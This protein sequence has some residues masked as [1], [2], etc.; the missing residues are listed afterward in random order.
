MRA[1]VVAS[2]LFLLF[3]LGRAGG[4]VP[5]SDPTKE[6]D[7]RRLIEL[8]GSAQLTQAMMNQM[9][10]QMKPLL[11]NSLP[12]GE[13]S[14]QIANIFVQKMVERANS[15]G[16]LKMVIPIYDKHLSHEE[17]KGLIQFYESPLGKKYVEVLPQMMQESNAAGAEWGHQITQEVLQDMQEQFPEL[18]KIH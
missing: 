17:I 15:E 16:F 11:I 1:K 12:P 6:A 4:A 10:Q 7:I 5:Q 2:G 13:R 8:T 3:C 14:E 9:A 18:K